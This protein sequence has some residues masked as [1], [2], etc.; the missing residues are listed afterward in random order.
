[1]RSDKEKRIKVMENGPYQVS[2]TTLLKMRPNLNSAGRP[3]KWERGQEIDR[4]ESYELCRCGASS[5]K[6][7]CDWTHVSIDFN[8]K[9][10]ADRASTTTR[11]KSY[12]GQ[13]LIM[14]DDKTLCV[15]AG[16]CV[17]EKT[18]VWDLVEQAPDPAAR[19]ELIGM[20]RNCPAGR[21]EYAE[22][23]KGSPVEEELPQEIG[24]IEDGPIYVR[25]GIVVEGANGESYEIRNRMTLCRCG[26]S[27]NKPFCDGRHAESGFRDKK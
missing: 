13:G 10:T 7:F 15:H 19:E 23:P 21:L 9:E 12:E 27:M 18:E 11:R 5:N 16:F 6:P 17:T 14:T 22:A 2:G 25:G 24:I 4:D 1:M 8:G 26:A 20:I 3:V